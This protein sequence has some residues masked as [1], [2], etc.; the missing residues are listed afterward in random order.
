[1]EAE[2]R[3]F[4]GKLF[5]MGNKDLC[6]I[7][8]KTHGLCQEYNALDEHDP[9]RPEIIRQFIGRIGRTF[10]ILTVTWDHRSMPMIYKENHRERF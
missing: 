6:E 7:K 9:R 1:M 2:D 10:I 5:D 3:I 4:Q 8:H